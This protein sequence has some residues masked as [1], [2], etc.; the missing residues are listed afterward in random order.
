[1]LEF[2]QRRAGIDGRCRFLQSVLEVGGEVGGEQRSG[3]IDENDVAFRAVQLTA[4]NSAGDRGVVDGC[5]AFEVG[6]G[7]EPVEEMI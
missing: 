1:M 6:V 2:V 5:A 3:G 7:A 4:E